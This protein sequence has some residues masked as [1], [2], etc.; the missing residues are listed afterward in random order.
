MVQVVKYLLEHPDC[1]FPYVR[2]PNY[3]GTGR[4]FDSKR[5]EYTIVLQRVEMNPLS[6]KES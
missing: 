1:E 3:S 2:K 6:E 5:K 4:S